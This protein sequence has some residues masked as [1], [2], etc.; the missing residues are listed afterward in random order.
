MLVCGS[1][2]NFDL[3]GSAPRRNNLFVHIWNI[4]L[5]QISAKF[6]DFF[7]SIAEEKVSALPKRKLRGKRWIKWGFC[8]KDFDLWAFLQNQP[9][10]SVYWPK[11]DVRTKLAGSHINSKFIGYKKLK[12]KRP[13]PSDAFISFLNSDCS[14]NLTGAQAACADINGL[15]C[16]V[17]NCFNLSYVRLPHSACL[18]VGVGNIVT[19]CNSFLTEFALCHLKLPSSK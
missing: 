15:V 14:L 6:S 4:I 1:I 9:C 19:K 16:S 2:S 12:Q 8:E 10:I 11:V 3:A 17:N 5:H 7:R 13:T 18:S